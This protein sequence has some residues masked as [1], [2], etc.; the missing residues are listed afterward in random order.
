MT[1][2][3]THPS[4]ALHDLSDARQR[5]QV[6]V[7]TMR[8]CAL[9]QGFVHLPQLGRLQLRLA[10]SPTRATQSSGS[11]ALPLPIPT[12]YTLATHFQFT[13]DGGEDQLAGSRL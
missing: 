9:P 4:Q 5:P 3:I 11:T 1:G 13:S 7:E 10:A 8:P 2:V 6:R 12:G